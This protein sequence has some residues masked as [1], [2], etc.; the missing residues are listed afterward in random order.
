ME[1][2]KLIIAHE[3]GVIS[4]GLGGQDSVIKLDTR[5]SALVSPNCKPLVTRVAAC[6]L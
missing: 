5:A 6:L 3:G 1:D 2:A 4:S